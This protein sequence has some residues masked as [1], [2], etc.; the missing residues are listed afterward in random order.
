MQ[1]FHKAKR[2]SRELSDMAKN[3]KQNILTAGIS[4]WLK[5]PM[6]VN[7]HAIARNMGMTH[8][9]IL[10]HFPKSV[11]DAVAE[12]AVKTDNV[13]I[14]VQLI[15]CNHEAIVHLTPAERA[16]YLANF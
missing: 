3:T 10:Y 4:M 13:K 5:D 7:A 12:Y 2:T 8:G 9:A 15:V 16:K 6:S 1:V 11:R 14:I